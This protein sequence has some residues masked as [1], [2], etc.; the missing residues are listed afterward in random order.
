MEKVR[1]NNLHH[2]RR[3]EANQ[4]CNDNNKHIYSHF[5]FS[6]KYY[7]QLLVAFH[8][9]LHLLVL[10]SDSKIHFNVAHD[11]EYEKQHSE[12]VPENE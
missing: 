9:V 8:C 6:L 4:K 11:G 12:N 10:V 3:T 2:H 5:L 1:K 7:T